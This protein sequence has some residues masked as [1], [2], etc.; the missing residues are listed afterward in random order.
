MKKQQQSYAERIATMRVLVVD[1]FFEFRQLVRTMLIRDIGVASVED[2][3]DGE[4]AL[5]ILKEEGGFDLVIADTTV[6]PMGGIALTAMIRTGGAKV[7]EHMPVIAVSGQPSLAD[8]MAAR[9]AGVD[10]YLAKPLSAKIL[11]LR[12]RS[13]IEHPR[14]F[15]HAAN[16]LGPERRRHDKTGFDG[17]ERRASAT[18][19][20]LA[21]KD[22]KNA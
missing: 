1:S 4:Q 15:V 5:K 7:D 21:A 12:I 10:E 16:F 6:R 22:S 14:P 19:E 2:A 9:D 18:R 11:E 8:I 13:V 17:V 20:F 3:K